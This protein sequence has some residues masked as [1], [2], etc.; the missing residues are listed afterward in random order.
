MGDTGLE[1]VTT[2]L[3]TKSKRSVVFVGVRTA[4]QIRAFRSDG[5]TKRTLDRTLN[6]HTV[7]TDFR[8]F[9][10]VARCHG[11]ERGSVVKGST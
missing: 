8:A 6:V 9:R 2:S 1:P 10:F 3:L 5:R 11:R 4:L 7:R